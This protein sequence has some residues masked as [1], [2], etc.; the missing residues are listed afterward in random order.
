MWLSQLIARANKDNVMESNRGFTIIELMIAALLTVIV[1]AAAMSLYLTQHKQL[2]VQDSISDMQSSLR[3]AA[4][5]LT[6]MVRLA[7]YRIPESMALTAFNTNPDTLCVAFDQGVTGDIQTSAATLANEEIRCDGSSLNGLNDNDC[8]YIYDP[9]ARVGEYFV[10]TQVL[11]STFRILHDVNL[12]RAYPMG[13]G[14][15]KIARFKYYID[16]TD[17]NHPNL[18]VMVGD[19]APQIYAENITNLNFSYLMST[20]AIVDVPTLPDMV[21]EVL[22]SMSGRTDKADN[23]FHSDYRFR[24]LTTRVKVRNLGVN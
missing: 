8:L 10:A 21:R 24:S 15:F 14:I 2:L 3:A 11:Q 4:A 19:D 20:G 9:A 12:T 17:A 16:R 18:M 23:D 22:I 7:G 6:S 1:S 5:E 13:S